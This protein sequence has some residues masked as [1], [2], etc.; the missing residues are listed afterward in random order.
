MTNQIEFK[1]KTLNPLRDTPERL[2]YKDQDQFLAVDTEGNLKVMSV[3]TGV[4]NLNK[5]VLKFPN[6][7]YKLVSNVKLT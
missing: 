4:D 2:G 5:P 3:Y 7:L 1:L 6:S